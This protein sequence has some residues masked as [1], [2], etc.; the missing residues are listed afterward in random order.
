MKDEVEWY[1]KLVSMTLDGAQ[2]REVAKS[3]MATEFSV[4]PDGTWLAFVEGY[5]AYLIPLLQTGKQLEIGPK[6]EAL[7]VRKLSVNAGENLHWAGDSR[8]VHFSLGD[9]L[10]TR[11]LKESFSFVGGAPKELPK[12]S[13][14]GVRIGFSAKADN[15]ARPWL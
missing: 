6:A 15:P 1:S 3:E 2:E 13:E 7:P 8:K 14:E 12:P 11:E 4:S 10:F 5:Q 9:Q